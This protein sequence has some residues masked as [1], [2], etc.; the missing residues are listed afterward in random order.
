MAAEAIPLINALL[1]AMGLTAAGSAKGKKYDVPEKDVKKLKSAATTAMGL[2]GKNP[3]KV[4]S[5][6]AGMMYDD[7]YEGLSE[8]EKQ[9]LADEAN[10]TVEGYGG[11]P[12]NRDNHNNNAGKAAGAAAGTTKATESVAKNQPKKEKINYKDLTY[13]ERMALANKHLEEGPN[14]L[15]PDAVKK[16]IKKAQNK[17]W[18][19]DRYENWRPL[20]ESKVMGGGRG[21]KTKGMS[22]QEAIDLSRERYLRNEPNYYDPNKVREA[23]KENAI[24]KAKVQSY[25]KPL[26]YNAESPDMWNYKQSP[27]E[28]RMTNKALEGDQVKKLLGLGVGGIIGGIANALPLAG[29]DAIEEEKEDLTDLLKEIQKYIYSNDPKDREIGRKMMEDYF[30]DRGTSM[31]EILKKYEE[32]K[33]KETSEEPKE[34]TEEKPDI[35][36]ANIKPDAERLINS[37]DPEDRKKGH[38]LIEKYYLGDKGEPT[39]ILKEIHKYIKSKDPKDREIGRKM[40]DDYFKDRSTSIEEIPKES[41][42]EKPVEKEPKKSKG[43]GLKGTDLY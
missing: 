38:E 33:A 17:A 31:E 6:I 9:K 28:T 24:T 36:W 27:E 34:S 10:A 2:T 40:M 42:E 43:K 13:K 29:A 11:D 25:E 5:G 8:E 15:D 32:Y 35:D 7:P 12:D 39:E 37:D 30:K 18:N 23:Q 22:S 19:N 21:N 26:E 1:E 16:G 20:D 14:V 3:L 4:A 41:T